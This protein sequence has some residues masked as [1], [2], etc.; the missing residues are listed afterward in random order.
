MTIEQYL[1]MYLEYYKRKHK[2]LTFL[3]KRTKNKRIKK[4]IEFNL[5]VASRMVDTW[6]EIIDMRRIEQ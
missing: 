5:K 1:D 3:L 6:K 4:K 2:R